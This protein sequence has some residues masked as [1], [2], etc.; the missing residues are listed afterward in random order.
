M[1]NMQHL[2]NVLRPVQAVASLENVLNSR[3]A[4]KREIL[5]LLRSEMQAVDKGTLEQAEKDL[6]NARLT[7]QGGAIGV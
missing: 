3:I 1:S 6:D 5:R 7:C 4:E 2:V